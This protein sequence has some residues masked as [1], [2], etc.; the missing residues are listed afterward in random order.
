MEWAIILLTLIAVAASFAGGRNYER[1]RRKA[2]LR[3]RA[4]GFIKLKKHY[5]GRI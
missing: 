1:A 3:K 2:Q 4:L 5:D